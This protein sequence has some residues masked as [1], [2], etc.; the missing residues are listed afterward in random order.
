MIFNQVSLRPIVANVFSNVCIHCV[1][2]RYIFLEALNIEVNKRKRRLTFIDYFLQYVEIIKS[3]SVV[4]SKSQ[5]RQHIDLYWNIAFSLCV[6]TNTFIWIT[7]LFNIIT[8]K[9]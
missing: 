1:K 5:K 4:W 7:G 6:Q 9:R 3:K 2:G 8:N